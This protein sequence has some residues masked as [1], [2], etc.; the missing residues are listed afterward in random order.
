VQLSKK[1]LRRSFALA[2]YLVLLVVGI[3]GLG[4]LVQRLGTEH[5]DDIGKVL[6]LAAAAIVL[7]VPEVRID[8]GR[9]TLTAIASGAAAV[10]LNPLDAT[11]VGLACSVG[12]ARRGGRLIVMNAV[13]QA[14][15]SCVCAVVAAQFYTADPLPLGVRVL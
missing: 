8:R 9:L 6:F 1:T 10:L 7:N 14:W 4:L 13:M 2:V 5:S 3:I 12:V 15:I 11:I